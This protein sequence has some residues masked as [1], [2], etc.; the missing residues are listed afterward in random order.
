[1]VRGSVAFLYG[2]GGAG[3]L[4]VAGGGFS[5]C[6]QEIVAELGLSRWSGNFVSFVCDE[7]WLTMGTSAGRKRHPIPEN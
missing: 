3:I 7:Q 6:V 4:P 1:M 2:V 5:E